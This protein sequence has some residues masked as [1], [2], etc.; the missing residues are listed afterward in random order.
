MVSGPGAP[1]AL[2]APKPESL[3]RVFKQK[4]QVSSILFGDA[5]VP[6]TE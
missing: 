5:M 4:T 2:I 1:Y 3:N 6:N